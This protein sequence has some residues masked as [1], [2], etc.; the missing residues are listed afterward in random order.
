MKIVIVEKPKFWGFFL[1]RMFGIKKL[2][3][4]DGVQLSAE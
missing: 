3:D 1:R 4:N 2:K